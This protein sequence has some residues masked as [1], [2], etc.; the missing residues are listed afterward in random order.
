M[1]TMDERVHDDDDDG[2]DD[3]DDPRTQTTPTRTRAFQFGQKSFYSIR[4][5]LPNRFFSIQ[6]DSAI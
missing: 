6:L 1:V 2:D 4:F 5:S 3:A